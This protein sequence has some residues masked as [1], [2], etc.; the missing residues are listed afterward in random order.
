MLV[1]ACLHHWYESL[2]FFGPV[3]VLG[4]WVWIS[5]RRHVAED[6]DD[7]GDGMAPPPHLTG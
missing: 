2:I 5:G 3:P 4:L 1:I 6:E 7:Q